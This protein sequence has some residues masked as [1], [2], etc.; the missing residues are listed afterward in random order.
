MRRILSRLACGANRS[1]ECFAAHN[2]RRQACATLWRG[3]RCAAPSDARRYAPHCSQLPRHSRHNTLTAHSKLSSGGAVNL[4][5][6]ALRL[7]AWRQRDSGGDHRRCGHR[8]RPWCERAERDAARHVARHAPPRELGQIDARAAA[9]TRTA[10]SASR[11]LRRARNQLNH[12]NAPRCACA[13]RLAGRL[14][15]M[16]ARAIAMAVAVAKLSS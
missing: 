8:R 5:R 12:Y 6:A 14:E 7:S 2:E 1:V 10:G 3:G 9:A 13:R 4:S 16:A 11:H 15:S